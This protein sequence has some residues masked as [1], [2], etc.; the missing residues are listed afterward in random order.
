[1][2]ADC[3]VSLEQLERDDIDQFRCAGERRE[4]L[5]REPRSGV[6]LAGQNLANGAGQDPLGDD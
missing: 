4:D 1:V 6:A 2:Q 5:G 3:E